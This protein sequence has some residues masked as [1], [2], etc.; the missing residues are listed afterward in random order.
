MEGE[1]D[2]S[3]DPFNGE[4]D[5]WRA[6]SAQTLVS[7]VRIRYLFVPDS[8]PGNLLLAARRAA[9]GACMVM[10]PADRVVGV[11]WLADALYGNSAAGAL[12]FAE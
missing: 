1:S 4:S 10:M 2:H 8:R 7:N 12:R 6:V 3:Y 9:R 5:V 11:E